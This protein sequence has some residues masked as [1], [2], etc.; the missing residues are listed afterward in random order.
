MMVGPQRCWPASYKDIPEVTFSEVNWVI[1]SDATAPQHNSNGNPSHDD[2]IMIK[3][4]KQESSS[5]LRNF[6]KEKIFLDTN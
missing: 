3:L 5:R 6:L 1:R 4:L 2:V